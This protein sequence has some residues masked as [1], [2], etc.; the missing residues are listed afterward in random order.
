ML[1][2][3]KDTHLHKVGVPAIWPENWDFI[4]A[5]T[6]CEF[7]LAHEKSSLASTLLVDDWETFFDRLCRL[8]VL[9]HMDRRGAS[10]QRR[11]NRRVT[12]S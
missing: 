7:V 12:P 8:H 5:V 4:A 3:W 6:A 9:R 1:N 2:E 11:G 10:D